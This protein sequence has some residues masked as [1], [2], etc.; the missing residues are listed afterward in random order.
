MYLV[1]P[2]VIRSFVPKP[3]H[4]RDG[5]SIRQPAKE[6]KVVQQRFEGRR[7]RY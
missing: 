3:D 5:E 2:P 6:T 4:T 7:V 1:G